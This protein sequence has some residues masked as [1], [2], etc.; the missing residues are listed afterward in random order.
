MQTGCYLWTGKK[1][2]NGYG[3]IKVNGKEQAAHR[4]SY[5]IANGAIPDGMCVLH[6]CDTPA[7]VNPE[8]L[9]AGT[10]IDNL[11]DMHAK[12]RA[13]GNTSNHRRDRLGRFA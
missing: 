12:G 2:K 11:R 6:R 9:F 5:A 13:R 3:R 4:V 8:H 7:C 1:N 10:V